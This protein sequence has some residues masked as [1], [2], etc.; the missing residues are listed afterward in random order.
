MVPANKC[1][2]TGNLFALRADFRL[3]LQDK[4]VVG[5]R[6]GKIGADFCFGC[7]RYFRIEELCLAQSV[8]AGGGVICNQF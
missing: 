3:V 5:N 2:D 7:S 4:L 6:F 1:F 8:E